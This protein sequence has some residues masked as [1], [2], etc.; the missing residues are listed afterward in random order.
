MTFSTAHQ[1]ESVHLSFTPKL[2]YEQLV[3][4]LLAVQTQQVQQRNLPAT[5]LIRVV[6]DGTVQWMTAGE[7]QAILSRH[8]GAS[9]ALERSIQDALSGDRET[10]TI[11]LRLM[12]ASTFVQ[13]QEYRESN[14]VEQTELKRVEPQLVRIGRYVNGKLQNLDEIE[15][16]ITQTREA[17]PIFNEFET[18]MGKML[19][20]QREG[21]LDEAQNLAQ[22][23]AGL[24]QR[25][26]ILGRG[27]NYV[28][29]QAYGLRN[30]L[31]RSKRNIISTQ[32]YLSAQ[33]R[34]KIA[35][36]INQLKTELASLVQGDIKAALIG[37]NGQKIKEIRTKLLDVKEE[38][39]T[40]KTA[41][42]FYAR[43]QKETEAVLDHI[44]N[45]VLKKTDATQPEFELT[46]D[47]PSPPVQETA[48]QIQTT[49]SPEPPAM[50]KETR[51]S[52]HRMATATRHSRT[53][54]RRS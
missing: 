5:Q 8:D 10:L 53:D 9:E 16:K 37:P 36:E 34:I 13:I 50:P 48:P 3:H 12:I 17:N 31:Q 52:S 39:S 30:D 7:A 1:P 18:L 26:V 15:T 41:S 22:K 27:L 28:T 32:R 19:I 14:K 25:Y 43:Q 33:R 20:S 21:R 2:S 54:R 29:N 42:E 40:L 4:T 47:V 44:A 6:N 45:H 51:S 23:L 11:E 49:V 24:K 46:A 38:A 35:S